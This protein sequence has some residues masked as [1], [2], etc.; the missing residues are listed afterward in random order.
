[1]SNT[2]RFSGYEM[3]IKS[4]KTTIDE[5]LKDYDFNK[6]IEFC[7]A[8]PNYDKIWSCPP[9]DFNTYDYLSEY[10]TVIIYSG[11]IFFDLQ[12]L[13]DQESI[14]KKT[15]VFDLGR[16][17]FRKYLMSIEEVH[18]ESKALIAGH[19]FLCDQ[20]TR[21]HSVPCSYPKMIRYSLEGMGIEVGTLLKRV[22]NQALQWDI[23]RTNRLMTVGAL[24]IK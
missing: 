11:E 18:N 10:S 6:I 5:L 1:M 24:L 2:I 9:F 13:N 22:L 19:C 14:S 15:I 4:K 7:K 8:C 20:C 12:N 3:N 16:R 17:E 23:E 21:L